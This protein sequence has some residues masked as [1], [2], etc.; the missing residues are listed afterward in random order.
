MSEANAERN[1]VR[2]S[3]LGGEQA[4]AAWG[5]A[6]NAC[7]TFARASGCPLGLDVIKW[8]A[9]K[10]NE[11]GNA[12]RDPLAA[13]STDGAARGDRAGYGTE[14]PVAEG[15]KSRDDLNPNPHPTPREGEAE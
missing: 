10:T 9:D 3:V 14:R 5:D 1:A 11:L 12:L 6:L 13:P 15:D 4:I 7:H 8:F 2:A